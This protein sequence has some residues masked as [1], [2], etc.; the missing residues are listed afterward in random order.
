M[1]QSIESEGSF[2]AA[3][4]GRANWYVVE[5]SDC[6]APFSKAEILAAGR[7]FHDPGNCPGGKWEE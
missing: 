1:F 3:P 5:A 6:V 7:N 4:S 2:L